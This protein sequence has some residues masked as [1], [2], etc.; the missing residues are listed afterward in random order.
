MNE[1]IV[2]FIK[3]NSLNLLYWFLFNKI[4]GNKKEQLI[5]IIVSYFNERKY[6]FYS[7]K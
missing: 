2:F 3:I 7:F 1:N 4:K 5:N 6:C